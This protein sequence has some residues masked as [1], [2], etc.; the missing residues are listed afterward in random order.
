MNTKLTGKSSI[1]AFR[2]LGAISTSATRLRKIEKRVNAYDAAPRWRR[3]LMGGR[4][5]RAYWLERYAF[6]L[7]RYISEDLKFRD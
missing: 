7:D 5:Y 2:V 6:E 4:L 3:W 1:W